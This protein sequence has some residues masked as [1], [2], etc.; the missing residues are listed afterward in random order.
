MIILFG[1]LWILESIIA[2]FGGGGGT[3]VVDCSV[4]I[5]VVSFERY[6]LIFV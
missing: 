1:C 4:V 2:D 6:I 5:C 3:G